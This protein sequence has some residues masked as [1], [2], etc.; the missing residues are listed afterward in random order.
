[1]T[2]SKHNWPLQRGFSRYYGIIHSAASYYNA[3]TLT[4]GN[5]FVKPDR[6][7]YY[8]TDVLSN[9]ASE[10]IRGAARKPDPGA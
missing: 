6:Q 5:E 7:G 2:D 9:R 3:A 4:D 1:V 10:Y 8:F